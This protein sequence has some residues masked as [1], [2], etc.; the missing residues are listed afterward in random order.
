MSHP[1]W[2]VD[3]DWHWLLSSI[4]VDCGLVCPDATLED[5][6]KASQGNLCYLA[7]PYSKQVYLGAQTMVRFNGD[8]GWALHWSARLA[9]YGVT[10]VS[11][12]VSSAYLPPFIEQRDPSF[13]AAWGLPLLLNSQCVIVPPLDDWRK[14]PDVWHAV[15]LACQNTKKT[16]LI[17]L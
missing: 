9:V 16:Y 2:P 5:V 15:Q 8:L 4:Y 10:A 11:Q 7:T 13:W 17:K 14:S 6:A 3:P 12:I 1:E